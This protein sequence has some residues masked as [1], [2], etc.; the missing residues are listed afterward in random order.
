MCSPKGEAMPNQKFSRRNFLRDSAIGV[1]A[2]SA[3]AAAALADP[4]LAAARIV[5]VKP[6]DLPDFTIKE[7]KV[8][9]TDTTNIHK[10]NSSETGEIVS[11]VTHDGV[12]GNYCLGN[13][14]R[15]EHW[16]DWAKPNLTG[17]SVLELLPTITATSGMKS[18]GGFGEPRQR[19]ASGIGPGGILKPPPSSPSSGSS[20]GFQTRGGGA[21]PDTYTSAA[22][23]C[24]WDILGKA[25]NQPVYKLLGGGS[26]DRLMAYASSQHLAA[27]EDYVA[28]VTKAKE[29]G[30]KGYKIHPGRGQHTKG[31]VI[32]SYVGHMEEI[33]EVR[34]AVGDEFVLM[35][36]P[37]QQYNRH[38]AMTVGRL[39]DEL[40]FAWFE[41]P[42]RTIDT[43][44]LVELCAALD[45]PIHVGEFLYSIAD[46]AEY[47]KRGAMDVVR[48]IAD[49]VGGM[50]GSMRV[51]LLADAFGMECTPHNWGNVIDLAVHFH[52]ELAL[53]NAYWFE[54]PFPAEYADRPYHKDKFRIDA[55]GYV[56]AP[57]APGLGYPIDR[58]VLDKMIIRID[59]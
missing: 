32:P 57:T 13:R 21:W 16:L 15:T 58:N 30:Y 26:K 51:G 59:R 10:L 45:T 39:L 19:P 14:S 55:D 17:K 4:G 53:P 36:D 2:G 47:I 1:A 33:R 27:V 28:D 50:S 44:G 25:V 35:H 8:Y 9:V 34:K 20:F 11:I 37:V 49:N 29:L 18:A 40:N 46:F 6:A 5:D 48:L 38:E 56:L 3:A 22:E 24:F 41:D 54:M 43:E 52:Q 12:E 7:V 23:I 31:P 42:T